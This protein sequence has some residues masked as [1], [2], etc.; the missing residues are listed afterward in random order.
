MITESDDMLIDQSGS[1]LMRSNAIPE[2]F[3]SNYLKLYYGNN[4]N[5]YPLR[6]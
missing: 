3:N 5:H 2:G 6:C 4:N 1:D